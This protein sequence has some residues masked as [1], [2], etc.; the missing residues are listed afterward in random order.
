MA[1]IASLVAGA[2]VFAAGDTSIGQTSG[3]EQAQARGF[4]GIHGQRPA[5]RPAVFGTV[6]A[7]S[8]NTITIISKQFVRGADKKTAP[9]PTTTT[10]NVD[11]TSAKVTKDNAASTVS[12]IAVGDTI[13][14][15]GIISGTNVTATDIRDGK[16]AFGPGNGKMERPEISTSTPVIGNGQPIVA[17]TI[18]AING[19]TVTITNKS[20]ATYTID[21]SSAKVTQGQNTISL[22][23]L[24]VGDSVIVQGTIN[25]TSVVA[26]SVIDQSKPAS[27]TGTPSKEK[28][29]GFFGSIGQFF[30]H[31]FGF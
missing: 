29:N 9:T 8:G 5:V 30:M 3:A 25:G 13:F 10:Y 14:A 11:A 19:T 4:G 23:N 18:S 31:L 24:N 1:T 15:Q 20:N 17:G 22:L 7:I 28:P 27:V 21:T 6:S 12:A 26:S 16:M 2:T